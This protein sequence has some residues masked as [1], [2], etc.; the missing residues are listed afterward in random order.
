MATEVTAFLTVLSMGLFTFVAILGGY[1]LLNSAVTSIARDSAFT[2]FVRTGEII[3]DSMSSR[4]SGATN[5]YLSPKYVLFF[6]SFTTEALIPYYEY[7]GSHLN[8]V[9]VNLDATDG[10]RLFND[11]RASST[12]NHIWNDGYVKRKEL[13]KCVNDVCLCL[14]EMESFL[15]FDQDYL[16]PNACVE[17]CWGQNVSN[18]DSCTR[19]NTGDPRSIMN[20]CNTGVSQLGG[21]CSACTSYMNDA[22]KRSIVRG[23][24]YDI[25]ILPSVMSQTNEVNVRLL[26]DFS[27]KTKFSFINRV[28]ECRTMASF[29]AT[30]GKNNY[31][32]IGSSSNAIPYLFNYVNNSGPSGVVAMISASQKLGTTTQSIRAS[33]II[34]KLFNVEYF[35]SNNND[36]SMDVTNPNICYTTPTFITAEVQ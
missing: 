28:L 4:T 30:A 8:S 10:T 35:Q 21:I 11:I 34:F 12:G 17:L 29:A 1:M 23:K 7:D 22:I 14:G 24:Y 16:K 9:A 18:Y 27:E 25:L 20:T 6:A 13:S 3:A 19:T 32:A 2:T 36:H 5:M 15:I 26:Q 33:D 31:C